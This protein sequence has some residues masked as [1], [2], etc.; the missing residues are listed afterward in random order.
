VKPQ[1]AFKLVGRGRLSRLAGRVPFGGGRLT[2]EVVNPYGVFLAKTAG[3]WPKFKAMKVGFVGTQTEQLRDWINASYNGSINGSDTVSVPYYG[4]TTPG[5]ATN[6]IDLGCAPNQVL[7]S[8]NQGQMLWMPLGDEATSGVPVGTVGSSAQTLGNGRNTS[9]QFV[10]RFN[11]NT[12]ITFAT[13][14]LSN[15]HLFSQILTGG[16]TLTGRIDGVDQA[17]VGSVT[18]TAL[19]SSHYSWGRTNNTNYTKQQ[20]GFWAICD[21]PLTNAEEVTLYNALIELKIAVG[22]TVSNAVVS[23]TLT[24]LWEAVLPD[25][26]TGS[27]AGKG[28]TGCGLAVRQSESASPIFKLDLGNDGKIDG[29]EP[30]NDGGLVQV[31]L[32]FS[33]PTITFD[34]QIS[35]AAA[36]LFLGSGQGAAYDNNGGDANTANHR[37]LVVDKAA[38][39]GSRLYEFDLSGTLTNTWD[40]GANLNGVTTDESRNETVSYDDSSGVATWRNKSTMTATGPTLTLAAG[41]DVMCRQIEGKRIFIICTGANGVDGV[42][43]VYTEGK[44][45]KLRPAFTYT[46]TGCRAIESV[47]IVSVGGVYYFL[48]TADEYRHGAGLLN[49]LCCY[50]VPA[51]MYA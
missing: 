11:C 17:T 30:A 4:L 33:G 44:F 51:A 2:R 42:L 27:Q 37:R 34:S 6:N 19:S 49:V 22:A 18:S 28:F 50:A 48:V 13:G 41:D 3:F 14:V 31:T 32:D 16:N 1:S 15:F 20:M 38:P 46:L 45:G 29:T 39:G 9:N 8:Q 10:G 5:Y 12:T 24:Q 21:T 25:G 26:G 7:S 35:F 40:L 36:S 47:D 23:Q 43:N